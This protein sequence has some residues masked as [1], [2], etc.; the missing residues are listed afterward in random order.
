MEVFEYDLCTL[1]W[2]GVPK[3]DDQKFTLYCLFEVDKG[4]FIMAS[5]KPLETKDNFFFPF[6]NMKVIVKSEEEKVLSQ[7][8]QKKYNMRLNEF[9]S[10]YAAMKYLIGDNYL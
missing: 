2:N 10:V 3:M 5:K 6:G 4:E 1:S 8:V 7:L 9:S